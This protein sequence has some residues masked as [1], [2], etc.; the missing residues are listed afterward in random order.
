[1]TLYLIYFLFFI[2]SAILSWIMGS[3]FHLQGSSLIL[4]R[5]LIMALGIG[6]IFAVYAFM[7]RRKSS[8]STSEKEQRH[9]PELGNLIRDAQQRLT[10]SQR[11]SAKTFDAT[12]LFY[13][14][15]GSNAAKTTT[16]LRSGLDPELLAGQVYRDQGVVPTELSTFWYTQQGVL[17]EAGKS[18]RESSYL[19][20]TLVRKTRPKM[21]Q[22][23]L[24]AKL[25]ARAAIVCT[26]VESF[27]G[28]GAS[29][30]IAALA[31]STNQMLRTISRRRSGMRHAIPISA[32]RSHPS[33]SLSLWKNG[34]SHRV[35]N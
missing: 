16:V 23:A 2:V 7:G 24:G 33:P 28:A 1:M 6:A 15:G 5:I 35:A 34:V 20:E 32:S 29:D 14:L 22:P 18:L 26:S 31:R 3:V 27:F 10:S 8:A 4:M 9:T 25:P 30:S 17:V 11:A 19:W 21:Y 12:P 13:I